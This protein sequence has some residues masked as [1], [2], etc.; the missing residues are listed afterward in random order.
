MWRAAP[1]RLPVDNRGWEARYQPL[2]NPNLPTELPESELREGAQT[3]PCEIGFE[4][5]GPSFVADFW[6]HFFYI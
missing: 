1:R 5:D 3:T 4:W 2:V 6:F